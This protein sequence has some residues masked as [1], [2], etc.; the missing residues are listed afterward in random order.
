MHGGDRARALS[1]HR[2]EQN[3]GIDAARETDAHPLARR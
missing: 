3:D 2:I 1:R